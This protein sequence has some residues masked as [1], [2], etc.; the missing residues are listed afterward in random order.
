MFL[1]EMMKQILRALAFIHRKGL[2]HRDI[3]PNN[4]L[5]KGI[6]DDG[7]DFKLNDFGK[8]IKIEDLEK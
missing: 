3:C 4:F 8:L 1:K 5:V 7:I 6:D 2:I